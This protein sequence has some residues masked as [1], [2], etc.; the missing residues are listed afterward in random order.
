MS[1]R[2]RAKP[3]EL[4]PLLASD[5]IYNIPGGTLRVTPIVINPEATAIELAFGAQTRLNRVFDSLKFICA[6]E[7]EIWDEYTSAYIDGIRCAL[8]E[9]KCLLDASIEEHF[10]KERKG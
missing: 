7:G 3:R 10:R 9:T 5:D 4:R 8:C 2:K 6:A 1:A